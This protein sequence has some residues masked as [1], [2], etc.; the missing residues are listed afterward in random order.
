MKNWFKSRLFFAIIL[1]IIIVLPIT[2][3]VLKL[4]IPIG[5]S[6][7]FSLTYRPH[8]D[9]PQWDNMPVEGVPY[10][11]YEWDGASWILVDSGITDSTGFISYDIARNVQYKLTFSWNGVPA[12]YIVENPESLVNCPIDRKGIHGDEFWL[13]TTPP[14]LLANTPIDIYF[15]NT[16]IADWQLVYT[17]TTDSNGL[18]LFYGLIAGLYT[19][20]Y[21][22][23]YD[24]THYDTAQIHLADIFIEP[25]SFMISMIAIFWII[26]IIKI[27]RKGCENYERNV[28]IV[29]TEKRR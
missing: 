6:A 12:E 1:I 14:Q 13:N 29:I 25:F 16:T 23:T 2:F 19:F 15:W 24:L 11:F 28:R 21:I 26:A 3:I 27:K 4:M 20:D 8:V 5:K 9:A 22:T 18:G 7:E 17:Y 10:E